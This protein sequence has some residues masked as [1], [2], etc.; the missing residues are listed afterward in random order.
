MSFW[1]KKY[2]IEKYHELVNKDNIEK[3]SHHS[4]HEIFLDEDPKLK[5]KYLHLVVDNWFNQKYQKT[6]SSYKTLRKI[7]K[8]TKLRINEIEKHNL[9]LLEERV[10]SLIRHLKSLNVDFK[11]L[12][13]EKAVI[14]FVDAQLYF[15]GKMLKQI[16][17]NDLIITNKRIIF[18]LG[19]NN[20]KTFSWEKVRYIKY[21]EYGI[22]FS[23]KGVEL[24]IRIHDQQTLANTLK[25]FFKKFNFDFDLEIN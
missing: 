15:E 3:I 24:V 10:F 19:T 17:S 5:Y 4:I 16:L 18:Y 23:Y 8:K 22:V 6:E 12:P 7:V 14:K 13:S 11:L 21:K 9:L 1:E 25:N 2:L 20:I